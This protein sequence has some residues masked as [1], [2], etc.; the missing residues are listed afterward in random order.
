MLR[1]DPYTKCNEIHSPKSFRV[2][3]RENRHLILNWPIFLLQATA[4]SPM[5]NDGHANKRV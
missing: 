3:T 2:V 4:R 1:L 5:S